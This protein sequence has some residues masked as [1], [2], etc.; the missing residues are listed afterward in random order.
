[1]IPNN[2]RLQNLESEVS[3]LNAKLQNL[4]QATQSDLTEFRKHSIATLVALPD[5]LATA[6]QT[7]LDKQS[8]M[9]NWAMFLFGMI[10]LIAAAV[11]GLLVNQSFS[12]ISDLQKLKQETTVLIEELRSTPSLAYE[13]L[14]LEELNSSLKGLKSQPDLISSYYE[15]FAVA[16]ELPT[17]A[18]EFFRDQSINQSGKIKEESQKQYSTLL[19]GK[20]IDKILESN[21]IDLVDSITRADIISYDEDTFPSRIIRKMIAAKENLRVREILINQIIPSFVESIADDENA[22]IMSE[23]RLA[24]LEIPSSMIDSLAEPQKS[25]VKKQ[26]EIIKNRK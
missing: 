1:V 21:D 3:T 26:L 22:R 7:V 9:I 6:E 25:T 16:E 12:N 24:L 15:R 5:K 19:V 14:R 20:F 4:E 13:R 8:K 17:D 11:I 23:T 2:T 18:F 10:S